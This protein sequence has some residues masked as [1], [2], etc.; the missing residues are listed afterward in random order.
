MKKLN[1]LILLLT[2]VYFV[3]SGCDGNLTSPSENDI[4]TNVKIEKEQE[5]R[6]KL[7]WNYNISS[8][9]TLEYWIARKVGESETWFWLG[10]SSYEDRFYFDDVNTNDSLVYAYKVAIYN[11]TED[12]ILPF[13]EVV[14]YLSPNTNPTNLAVA[15]TE[16][17]I[18]Q[19]SWFDRCVGEDGYYL[20]K[21]IGTGSWQSKFKTLTANSGSYTDT[22]S[23]YETV[24]YRVRTF[25]GTTET[26]GTSTSITPV[27]PAPSNLQ[28]EQLAINQLQITWV[29]NSG[30]EIAF[31]IDRKLN[32]EAWV[33]GYQTVSTDT[34]NFIDF[35]DELISSFVQ[36]RVYGVFD[37]DHVSDYVES[38]IIAMDFD[39]PSGLS[40]SK[41]DQEVF[42]V[43]W[44]DNTM[45]EDGFY[46]DV[47]IGNS[48]WND[49]T[50]WN[51]GT[52]PTECI[53]D[54]AVIDLSELNLHCADITFKV[55]A[56]KGNYVSGSSEEV[57]S[58]IRLNQVGDIFATGDI[59]HDVSIY[60]YTAYLANNYDGVKI[61]DINTPNNANEIGSIPLSDR[62]NGVY[63]KGDVLYAI[64]QEGG[65]IYYNIEDVSNPSLIGSYSLP[66]VLN[67]MY[68]Q[69]VTNHV[70]LGTAYVTK[71]EEG[72][73]IVEFEEGPPH[74]INLINTNGDAK[75]IYVPEDSNY[76]FVANGSN[77]GFLSIDITD[78]ESDDPAMYHY[79]TTG[80]G[81]DIFVENDYAYLANGNGGFQII[82]IMDVSNPQYVSECEGLFYVKRV[83]VKN[84][85]AYILDSNFGLYVINISD[86][87]NPFIQGSFEMDNPSSLDILGSYLYVTNEEGMIIL[88]I[89]E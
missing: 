17:N 22:T 66:G 26:S 46:V 20:D 39:I 4:P 23:L 11:A 71:G 13:S 55:R 36:Y 25:Y 51:G 86:K 43:Q 87:D 24:E 65:F 58:K 12:E 27:L 14:A 30:H 32:N 82:D 29:D 78:P 48:E 62:T 69:G 1:Y 59:V 28:W 38:D 47:K 44:M 68:I 9:D 50:A 73:A 64:Y 35:D 2:V 79:Q 6:L 76:A 57:Y 60:D 70:P 34:V 5:G 31:K 63:V 74:L 54:I 18:V 42:Q 16:Q 40:V 37:E 67:G 84:D 83:L 33:I 21:K 81:L 53:D 10:V 19:V 77:A 41:L 7:T 88:Q 15:Q 3:F 45:G 56:F 89:F 72:I 75:R 8:D 61:I 80:S 85:F 49:F 52:D